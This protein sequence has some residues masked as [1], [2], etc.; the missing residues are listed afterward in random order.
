ML[1]A[2][3]PSEDHEHGFWG[4]PVGADTELK[5]LAHLTFSSFA[6]APCN[7]KLVS[8]IWFVLLRT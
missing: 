6:E 5:M 8:M 4:R 7:S 2:S 1:D 3:V